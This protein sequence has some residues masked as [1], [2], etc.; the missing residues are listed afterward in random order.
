MLFEVL[1]NKNVKILYN[2]TSFYYY[3][4]LYSFTLFVSM[5]SIFTA[6]DIQGP[7]LIELCKYF[8]TFYC[9]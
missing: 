3:Y 9:I 5:S 1:F 4:F 2:T 8:N 7:Q 6:Q